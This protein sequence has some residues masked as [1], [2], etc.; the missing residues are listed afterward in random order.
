MVPKK[1]VSRLTRQ[2]E[3]R[4]PNLAISIPTDQSLVALS[5]LYNM[6]S[7]CGYQLGRDCHSRLWMSRSHL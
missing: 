2:Y 1:K 7:F 5:P 4:A 3:Q 6:I